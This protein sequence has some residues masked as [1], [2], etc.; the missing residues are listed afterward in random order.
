MAE[1]GRELPRGGAE[2]AHAAV[3][4]VRHAQLAALLGQRQRVRHVQHVLAAPGVWNEA[5]VWV[6]MS[7]SIII[8]PLL[9]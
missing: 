6:T 3:L 8:I 9:E 4:A 7:A 2:A 1:G 5:E